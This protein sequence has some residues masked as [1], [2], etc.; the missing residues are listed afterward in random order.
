MLSR[1]TFLETAAGALAS[2]VLGTVDAD[3]ANPKSA[4]I[5]PALLK[6]F[7]VGQ[8]P[9]IFTLK[10]LHGLTG[11][12]RLQGDYVQAGLAFKL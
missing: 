12:N 7:V 6:V 8:R 9:L 2:G 11:E 5:G 3:P 10:W 1:R 4:G